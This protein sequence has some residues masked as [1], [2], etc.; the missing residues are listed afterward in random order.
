[1]KPG[2][3]LV[4]AVLLFAAPAWS[5]GFSGMIVLS[6]AEVFQGGLVRITVSGEEVAE[7]SGFLTNRSIAFFAEAGG[8]YSALLGVDLEHKPGPLAITIRG[9][10]KGKEPWDR[11]LLLHVKEKTFP[12][13][14]L[15]VPSTF[16]RIDEATRKRIERER[17]ALERLWA[18]ATP[19]R[20]WEGGF[21][22]P[23]SG[24]VT[25]PF[26]LRRIINGYPRLPHG[27]VDLKGS[28]GTEIRAANHGRVIVRDDF[29]F[30]GKSIVVDHGAGLYTMY[31]HLSDFAV[32][33]DA[34]V[35]KGDVIGRVGMSGRVTGPHLHWGARL[36][37]ARIDPFEMVDATVV[38]PEAGGSG[39]R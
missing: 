25:S 31:F 13:E 9:R 30:S 4:F 5:S 19:R 27:G 3:L 29:Y 36:N 1:M 2:R 32:E 28:L 35:R 38:K 22:R 11:S 16:D 18:L 39:A 20:L 7:V 34:F 21:V 10:G 26:G 17:A 6:P 23:V 12:H 15:T 24:G 37:G 33:K 8:S 14:E